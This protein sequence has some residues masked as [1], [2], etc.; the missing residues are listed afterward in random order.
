MSKTEA[1]MGVARQPNGELDIR[2]KNVGRILAGIMLRYPS[3]HVDLRVI[4]RTL[5]TLFL[6]TDPSNGETVGLEFSGRSLSTKPISP[7]ALETVLA[8]GWRRL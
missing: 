6:L 7:Q 5:Q 2:K 4:P 1:T 3:H 8:S